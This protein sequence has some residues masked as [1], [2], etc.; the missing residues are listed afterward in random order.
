MRPLLL[1]GP[2]IEAS[3]K[4]LQEIKNKFNPDNIVVFGK[5]EEKGIILANLQAQSLFEGERL[6]VL[7]NPDEFFTNYTLYSIPYTLTLW[8]D[9]EVDIKKWPGFE[10]HLFPESKDVSIFP[11]L[12]YLAA[13][14]KRAYLEIEKIKNAGFDINYILTM[15]FY[16]LRNL[17]ATPLKAPDFVKK[18]LAKQRTSFNLESLTA[19]YK[20]LLEIDFKIKSGFLEKPQA[21]FLLTTKFLSH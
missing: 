4:K 12:D 20:Y 14:D 5:G 16:L 15:V 7:E 18:K 11:F 19:L 13:K 6:I 8:F 2:A 10:Y 3:R 1:H 21:E 9:H 17:V